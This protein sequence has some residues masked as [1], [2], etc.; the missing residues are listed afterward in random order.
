M[1]GPYFK[2]YILTLA[3]FQ[4]LSNNSLAG[5][6][7]LICFT[8]GMEGPTRKGLTVM[9]RAKERWVEYYS[10]QHDT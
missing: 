8:A 4:K 7:L 9:G 2:I 5:D 1:G 6:C 10:E 3:N